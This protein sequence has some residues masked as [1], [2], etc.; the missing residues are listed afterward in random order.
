ML[1]MKPCN[2]QTLDNLPNIEGISVEK[3]IALAMSKAGVSITITSCT[4]VVGFAIGAFSPLPILASICQTASMGIFLVYI[5]QLTFIV[6]CLTLDERRRERGVDGC[7][8]VK[9]SEEKVQQLRATKRPSLLS[10]FFD[11]I[12]A[13]LIMKKPVKAI[14]IIVT[15]CL[16]GGNLYGALM[17]KTDVDRNWYLP[18]ETYQRKFS[19]R[20]QEYFPDCGARG[21]V[22]LV[23]S[24][25][26]TNFK[27]V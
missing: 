4:D 3:R 1:L 19:E 7:C 6:P 12:V 15:M 22:Y 2:F 11:S 13:D 10:R 21:E 17:L 26:P 27:V 8:C 9:L 14:I 18:S 20:L 5:L 24:M 16:F 25:K 23:E